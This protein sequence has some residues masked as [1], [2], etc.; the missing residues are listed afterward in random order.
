MKSINSK[1]QSPL[2]KIVFA[3]LF[4][5][6]TCVA[7]MAIRV[8]SP[9]G[10]ANLGD[11]F[12][13]CSGWVLGP[14]WGTISAGVGSM[15]ADIF[16]GYA[17]YAPATLIIKGLMALAAF[18]IYKLLCKKKMIAKIISAVVAECIMIF[19]Y[20]LFSSL[21]LGNEIAAAASSIISDSFQGIVGIIAG[22]A[23]IKVIEKFKLIN[24]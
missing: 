22:L 5:A 8:P 11:C 23:L 24:M 20:F 18:Y 15:F 7:T 4:A 14:V 19:G 12:V 17:Y 9:T 21:V 1:D 10:Y 2:M 16:S 6:L 3:A 13:L